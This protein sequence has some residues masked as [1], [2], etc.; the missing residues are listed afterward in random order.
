MTAPRTLRLN[1][2][3]LTVRS[4]AGWWPAASCR[5]ADIE[6][7]FPPSGDLESVRRALMI[8]EQCPVQILCR[9][10]ALA[11]RERHGIWGGLTEET[12]ETLLHMGPPPAVRTRSPEPAELLV[13]PR[14]W[15]AP[16]ESSW[17]AP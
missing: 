12:R 7:F 13:E 17:V 8:C 2:R 14:T 3:A 1:N 5:G 4:V 10:Y 6:T 11:H 16:P 15:I 9:Q